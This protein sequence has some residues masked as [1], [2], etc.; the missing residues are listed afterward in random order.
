[1]LEDPADPEQ[2]VA[3]CSIGLV[4]TIHNCGC[5]R[6]GYRILYT[7]FNRMGRP[8]LPPCHHSA[9]QLT[10]QYATGKPGAARPA[11]LVPAPSV[12]PTAAYR[13]RGTSSFHS[14]TFITKTLFGSFWHLCA[15]YFP[16]PRG[17]ISATHNPASSFVRP[18]AEKARLV[19]SL[20]CCLGHI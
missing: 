3:L 6:T 15:I 11:P 5:D 12:Q 1:M 16:A 4:R 9:Q 18:T 10:V 7:A 13:P 17:E 14:T 20:G 8:S 19:T 2:T